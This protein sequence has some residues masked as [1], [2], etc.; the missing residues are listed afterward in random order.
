MLLKSTFYFYFLKCTLKNQHFFLHT[1]PRCKIWWWVTSK[2]TEFFLRA[3]FFGWLWLTFKNIFNQIQAFLMITW[4]KF[5]HRRG[6]IDH[7]GLRKLFQDYLN[8]T[9]DVL[10]FFLLKKV[11]SLRRR[12]RRRRQMKPQPA[13]PRD[14]K[15][16]DTQMPTKDFIFFCRYLFAGFWARRRFATCLQS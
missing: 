10:F 11:W 12:R 1:F 16:E 14:K 15:A 4:I 2:I 6:H 3:G 13:P 9:A 8:K 5:K 7:C